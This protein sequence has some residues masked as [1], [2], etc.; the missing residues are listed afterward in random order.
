MGI[1]CHI[2]KVPTRPFWF[3]EI[4]SQT[5]IRLGLKLFENLRNDILISLVTLGELKL[6][7]SGHCSYFVSV[8]FK[9]TVGLPGAGS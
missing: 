1:R 2:L 4:F 6:E 5:I 8:I 9:I 3:S 7:I